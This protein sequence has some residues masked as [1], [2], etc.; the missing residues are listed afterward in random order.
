[1]RNRGVTRARLIATEACRS[2]G[3]GL[4]FLERVRNEVG[5]ELEIVDRETEARLA[6]TGCT[7]LVDPAADGVILFDIGGGSSELVRL[8]RCAPT[9]ARPAA[10]RRSRPGCRCRSAS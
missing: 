10:S 9:A 1:M 6:A 4:D 7:P 2:A 3:N 8:G 5:I